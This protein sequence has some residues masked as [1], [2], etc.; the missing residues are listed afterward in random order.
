MDGIVAPGTLRLFAADPNPN[1]AVGCRLSLFA[2]DATLPIR[3]IQAD[4]GLALPPKSTAPASRLR[5]YH[6]NDLHGHL[7]RF[8]EGVE[9]PVLSRLAWQIRLARQQSQLQSAAVL[10]VSAGDDSCGSIFDEYLAGDAHPGY[11]LYTQMGVDAA[12]LGNH[13]LDRGLSDLEAAVWR[14]ARFP[15]LAANL[16]GCTDLRRGCHPAALLTLEGLRIGLIGLVTRAETRLDPAIGQIVHPIPVAQNLVAALRPLCDVLI[17]ITHL[18][19][20]LANNTVPMADAGD[21]ELARS[22]PGGG[23]D[24]IV[25]G[26]SHT[27][28]NRDGLEAQNIVNGIPIVQA[29]ANGEFLGQVDLSLCD[30][31]TRVTAA[32]LI[33]VAGLPC[34]QEFED[35]HVQPF[36]AQARALLSQ[37]LGRVADDPDLGAQVVQRDF[38]RRELALANFVSDALVERLTARGLAVDLALIDASALHAGLPVGGALRYGDW[39]AVMPYADTIRLYR[40]TSRQLGELLADNALRLDRPGEPQTERGFL[41]FSRSV[42]YTIEPGASRLAARLSRAT[43]CATPLEALA[44]KSFTVATSCFTRALAAPWEAAWNRDSAIPLFD[45]CQLPFTETNLPLR[46]EVVDYI[47]ARR[48]VTSQGGARC[49]GRLAIKSAEGFC[50]LF[51][52]ATDL[53]KE[54]KIWEPS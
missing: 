1:G 2:G 9:E 23:V 54:R 43:V 22:L 8:R 40:L 7:S 37:P 51:E 28:L 3:T 18:G 33:P 16:R 42:R 39:F 14:D 53:D 49:D 36:V 41:Q 27:P 10:V 4:V 24:L 15:L 47:R 6:F 19:Y 12:G 46:S 30:Q 34:E 20:S 13:D 21:V 35:R 44:E 52:A 25:G 50:K 31:G 11:R 48:G 26:H 5:V 32:R 29:G 38:A 17:L 45:L